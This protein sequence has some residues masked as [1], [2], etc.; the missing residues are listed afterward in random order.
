MPAVHANGIDIYYE[1][2]G[3]EGAP[4][5]LIHGHS[6]D[7][8]MWPAQ[9]LALREAGYR[10][11]RYDVRGHGRSS[12]PNEGYTWPVYAEDLRALLD[13]LDIGKAHLVG[14]SMGGGIA[15]QFA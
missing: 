8:R 6:V 13:T 1:D 9:V 14:F 2:T 11:V 12:V 3:G 10:V 4:V 15:L 7:L 5:V